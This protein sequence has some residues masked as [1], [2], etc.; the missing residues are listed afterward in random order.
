MLE[1]EKARLFCGV[2]PGADATVLEFCMHAAV[3]WLE[4]AGCPD[5][6]DDPAYD[7]VALQ[8]TSW[9]FDNRGLGD[10][11]A[12]IPHYIVSMVHQLRLVPDDEPGKARKTQRNAKK[13][14]QEESA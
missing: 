6:D 5:R 2:G 3:Q 11:D 1:L 13:A 9:Y 10:S 8:L 14:R 12:R 7:L 4:N